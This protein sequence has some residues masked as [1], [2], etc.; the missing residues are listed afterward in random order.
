MLVLDTPKNEKTVKAT[1]IKW[2]IEN[3][4]KE[5]YD[6]LT[7]KERPYKTLLSYYNAIK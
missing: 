1:L 2:A 5:F 3:N 4:N 7:S 6:Y